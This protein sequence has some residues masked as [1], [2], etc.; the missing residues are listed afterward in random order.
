MFAAFFCIEGGGRLQHYEL[1]K[2]KPFL[3]LFGSEKARNRVQQ[4]FDTAKTA[5]A[6]VT[7][8]EM[9]DAGHN[10]PERE[11]PLVRAWLRE[12]ANIH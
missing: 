4:I 5:G 7:L 9:K 6:Q 11:Y 10:F 1:L 2:G 8:H 3:M 12:V